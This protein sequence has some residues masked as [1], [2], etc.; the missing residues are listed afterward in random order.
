M[1]ELDLSV[2]GLSAVLTLASQELRSTSQKT[3][4]P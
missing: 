2:I 1:N 3:D 4:Y